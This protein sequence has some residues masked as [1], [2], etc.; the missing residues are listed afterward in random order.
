MMQLATHII[1]CAGKKRQTKMQIQKDH[2]FTTLKQKTNKNIQTT[3]MSITP[4]IF[5]AIHPSQHNMRLC[6]MRI[7]FFITVKLFIT[8]IFFPLLFWYKLLTHCFF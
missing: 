3:S 4:S 2:S 6:N 8:V 5:Q 7:F 1:S